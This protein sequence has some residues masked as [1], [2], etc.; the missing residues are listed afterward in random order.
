MPIVGCIC[1]SKFKHQYSL[2]YPGVPMF[3]GGGIMGVWF[4]F[5]P[6]IVG[7]SFVYVSTCTAYNILEVQSSHLTIY[8]LSFLK[9]IKK[10]KVIQYYNHLKTNDN[11]QSIRKQ[12]RLLNTGI[13]GHFRFTYPKHLTTC[14][15]QNT[16]EQMPIWSG[17]TKPEMISKRV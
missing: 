6:S 17:S 8:F 5:F 3:F 2:K 7:S 10:H 12:F 9:D 16:G 4:F 1:I 15:V 14:M 11:K 13:Q